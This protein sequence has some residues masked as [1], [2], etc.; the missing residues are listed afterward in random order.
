MNKY[1]DREQ[2][3]YY[4]K[5]RPEYTDKIFTEIIANTRDFDFYVD[6][7]CGCGQVRI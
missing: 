7:A 4:E 5:Y 6:L 1:V 2:I 3:N